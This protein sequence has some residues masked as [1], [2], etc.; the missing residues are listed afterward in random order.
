MN[1]KPLGTGAM[2]W[3]WP[4]KE[5][6]PVPATVLSAA[7]ALA[8]AAQHLA[9]E[10]NGQRPWL[11]DLVPAYNSLALVFDPWQVHKN[12]QAASP[13][14]WVKTWAEKILHQLPAAP[15]QASRQLKVPVCYDPELAPDLVPVAQQLGLSLNELVALHSQNTYQVCFLGFLPGFPY[16]ATTPPALR[17]PRQATPRTKVPAGSVGLAEWQTGIY[18]LEAPGG[19]Q[20]IGRTPW[21]IFDPSREHPCLFQAGDQVVFE[22]I[23]RA[24]F[25]HWS[26]PMP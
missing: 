8:A 11:Q 24:A 10:P 26:T 23:D 5:G 13:S 16:M 14:L 6:C 3:E 25:D 20:I 18:P 17:L 12:F 7:A 9:A 2:L 22:P 4:A 1:W 19:W 21:V 15:Q